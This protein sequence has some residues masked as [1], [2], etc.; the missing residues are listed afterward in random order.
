MSR[1]KNLSSRTSRR[2]GISDYCPIL[3]SLS[4]DNVS[5]VSPRRTEVTRERERERERERDQQ[6]QQRVQV[7]CT[8][9]MFGV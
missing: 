6:Q 4:S 2:T 7:H 3:T 8:V 9:R 5:L 1:E